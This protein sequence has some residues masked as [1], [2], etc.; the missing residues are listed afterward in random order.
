M[1]N[2]TNEQNETINKLNAIVL[3]VIFEALLAGEGHWG[4]EQART[5]AQEF[6]KDQEECELQVKKETNDFYQDEYPTRS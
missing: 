4:Y 5:M 2:Q 3:K 6:I 1:T